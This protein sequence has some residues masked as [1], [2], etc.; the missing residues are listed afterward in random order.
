MRQSINTVAEAVSFLE[1]Q[2]GFLA[3]QLE[4]VPPLWKVVNVE[5]GFDAALTDI[6]L[7]DFARGERDV[8]AAMAAKGARD[9]TPNVAEAECELKPVPVDT[10]EGAKRFLGALDMEIIE[11]EG[12]IILRGVGLDNQELE[13]TCDSEAELVDYARSVRE[14]YAKLCRGQGVN[15]VAGAVPLKGSN[16]GGAA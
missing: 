13:L 14:L 2:C 16:A 4:I 5:I 12:G 6:E 15:A 7:L 3:V 11:T 9:P 8:R 1:S 10:V